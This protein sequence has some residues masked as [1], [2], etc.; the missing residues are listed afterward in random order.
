LKAGVGSDFM[1]ISK[2]AR[3]QDTLSG[4]MNCKQVTVSTKIQFFEPLCDYIN[5]RG[6]ARG[7]D[8]RAYNSQKPPGY[9]P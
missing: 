7:T 9:N 6:R 2:R 1:I 3:R 4:L 8:R 5:I